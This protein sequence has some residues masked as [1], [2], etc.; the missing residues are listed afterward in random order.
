[1]NFEKALVEFLNSLFD[2][3]HA[4]MEMGG[5]G[6]GLSGQQGRQGEPTGQA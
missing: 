6:G 5:R 2:R 1:M 4:R 3:Y